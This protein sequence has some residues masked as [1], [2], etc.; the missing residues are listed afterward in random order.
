MLAQTHPVP[1]ARPQFSEAKFGQMNRISHSLSVLDFTQITADQAIR[2]GRV[3]FGQSRRAQD[4]QTDE[5]LKEHTHVA[6][7]IGG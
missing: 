5:N 1:L 3:S 2:I 7:R 4:E 6:D